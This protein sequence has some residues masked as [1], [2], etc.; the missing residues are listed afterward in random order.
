LPILIEVVAAM[1]SLA[2]GGVA[3]SS[4]IRRLLELLFKKLG[5][6]P[7]APETYHARL[8]RLTESLTRSSEEVDQVLD[9]LRSVAR[10]RSDAVTALEQDLGSLEAKEKDLQQRITVLQNIPVPVAEHFVALMEKGEGRSARR[11]YLLFGAGVVV[12]TAIAIG[13]KALGLA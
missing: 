5:Q 6:K 1:A 9:E 13:L 4:V 8:A 12:S 10:A 7:S 2:V 11:D 3:S